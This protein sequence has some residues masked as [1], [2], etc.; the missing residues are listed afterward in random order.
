MDKSKVIK[1]WLKNTGVLILGYEA[2]ER[3]IR[4]DDEDNKKVIEALV[5]PGSF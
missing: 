4:S 3:L 2:Y 1:K 5:D